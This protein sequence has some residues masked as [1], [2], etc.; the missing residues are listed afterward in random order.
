MKTTAALLLL[1]LGQVRDE[2]ISGLITQLGSAQFIE[3][4]A[5]ATALESIG[6]AALP[7]L[8]NASHES[9]DAE[10][11]GAASKLLAKIERSLLTSATMVKLDIRD[12][13]LGEAIKTL[14]EKNHFELA[15]DLDSL[16]E[17]L[18]HKITL[19]TEKAVPLLT[20]LD[21]LCAAGQIRPDAEDGFPLAVSR[22]SNWLWF[23][24][25][26]V[27]GPTCD[28]GPFRIKILQI[29]Y[30]LER[31]RFLDRQAGQKDEQINNEHAQIS[32]KLIAEPR[33]ILKQSDVP[34]ILEVVDRQNRSLIPA[35]GHAFSFGESYQPGS[36]LRFSINLKPQQLPGGA[37]K[38]LRGQISV[39]VGELNPK[40]MVVP[41]A[42][43]QGKSF[44]GPDAR[45]TIQT[46]QLEPTK[47][48]FIKL[49]IESRLEDLDAQRAP[50]TTPFLRRQLLLVDD[51]G[52]T[53]DGWDGWYLTQ[54]PKG[55][56]EVEVYFAL[57]PLPVQGG[58]DR[59][60]PIVRTPAKLLFYGIIQTTVEIP[61]QFDDVPLP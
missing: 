28:S 53:I 27:S 59:R 61:F 32:L 33:L 36:E 42:D 1:T 52:K 43:S 16:N 19:R 45:V 4:T 23:A 22:S 11:R 14:G 20:A 34:E 3:R 9:S 15:G 25:V 24:P 39:E 12:Q 2:H 17:R 51:K 37:I 10:I 7:A 56:K 38:R 46:V 57:G 54:T 48:T 13:A 21:R 26:G 58:D 40:P 30:S 41:L 18:M 5:A 60:E 50:H 49:L 8:W 6:R 47:L 35:P 29:G 44:D 55:S 31:T